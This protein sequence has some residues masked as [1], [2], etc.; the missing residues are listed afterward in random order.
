MVEKF[1]EERICVYCNTPFIATRDKT[2][3]C[4]KSCTSTYKYFIKNG[5]LEKL[6]KKID[7]NKQ[8]KVCTNCLVEK[9]L[10]KF[11]KYK[12]GIFSFCIECHEEKYKDRYLDKLNELKNV[13]LSIYP[14]I[15]DFVN[16]IKRNN[17]MATMLDIFI[18]VDLFDKVSPQS[19]I[20]Y[21]GNPD[22]S[23]STMFYKICK[24][25]IK[26][27]KKIYIEL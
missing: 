11:F 13:D 16:R 10:Y 5:D 17:Y 26:E 7:K 2:I 12:K 3:F 9:P 15:E 19:N 22:K 6:Q 27:R 4:S 14:E 24:W 25:Y 8:K 23:F 18:L 21:D 20:P 1:R